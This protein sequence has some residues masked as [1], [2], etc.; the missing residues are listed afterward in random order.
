M[1]RL[2]VIVCCQWRRLTLKLC[3]QATTPYSTARSTSP[4]CFCHH[5]RIVCKD[6]ELLPLLG[7][8][9]RGTEYR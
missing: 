2:G 1:R 5:L 4:T 9:L 7:P 8:P 3:D 6:M